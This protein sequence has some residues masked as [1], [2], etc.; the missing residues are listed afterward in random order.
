MGIRL[1]VNGREIIAE[2]GETILSALSRHGMHVPTICNLKELSPTGACRMCVVEVEGLENLVP[3]CSFPVEGELKIKTHS[4]RVLRA[5]KTNVELLL[6]NHPDDCLYCERNLSCELQ[7]LAEHLHIRER[8]IPG[9]KRSGGIDRTSPAIVL[10][11]AKCILC[12]RCVRVCGEIMATSTLDFAGRGN[13]LKISTSLAKTLDESNCTACGQCLNVCPTG[14]LTENIQF[15]GLE[16]HLSDPKALVMVQYTPAVAV[17]LGELLGYRPGTDLGKTIPVLL[18]R[19]GF[20]FVVESSLGADVM[21][22]EQA[23]IFQERKGQEKP[24]PLIT[25]SCP[26]WVQFCEMNFPEL[27]PF[28]SPLRSPAQIT[29]ILM[30]ERF[31]G[32]LMHGKKRVISVLVTSCTAAK[33]EAKSGEMTPQGIPVI[34]F[35][36]TTRELAKMIRLSGLDLEKLQSGETEAPVMIHGYAGKLT[37][38]AG[39]EAECLTRSIYRQETGS[40][41]DPSKLQRFRIHKSYREATVKTGK[42]SLRIGAVNGLAEAVR[43]LEEIRAGRTQL[44]LLEVMACPDGCIN[45]GGQPLRAREQTLRARTKAIFDLDNGAEIRTAHHN[46][47]VNRLYKDYLGQSGGETSR[48]LFQTAFTGRKDN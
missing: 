19:L 47:D 5:R 26:A 7:S 37:A 21:I 12:G 33:R 28:L 42:G 32:Q 23:A 31:A 14:A 18:R 27:L 41:M 36:L 4:S 29:G 39:G 22:M 11:P 9:K 2:K 15:P 3:A 6:S 30:K 13:E 20:D 38:A 44:D 35:V 34:D 24:Y 46:P 16:P 48:S 43:L 1:E 10:D 17:S 45:G 40:E 25:S 8:R